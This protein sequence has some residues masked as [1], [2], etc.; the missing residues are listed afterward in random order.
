M[1]PAPTYSDSITHFSRKKYSYSINQVSGTVTYTYVNF[2]PRAKNLVA[3]NS[4]Q[5]LPKKIF[6]LEKTP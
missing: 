2:F 3:K 6:A 4:R 5:E 1:G